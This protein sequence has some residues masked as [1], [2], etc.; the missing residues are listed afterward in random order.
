MP[1]KTE[2]KITKEISPEEIII[3][4]EALLETLKKLIRIPS[5]QGPPAP[6]AP[7]GR[8]TADALDFFLEEADGMGFSVFNVDH[9]AGYLEWGEGEETFGILAHLDVVPAGNN[10]SVCPAY[11]P[12]VKNGRLYGRGCA[13]DKGPAVASLYALKALK[14]AGF[15]PKKKIRLILGLNEESGFGGLTYYLSKHPHV[16]AGF[17][18]DAY[19]PLVHGEKGILSIRYTGSEPLSPGAGQEEGEAAPTAENKGIRLLSIQ[20]GDAL[21]MVASGAETVLRGAP[22]VLAEIEQK[23]D[24]F[25]DENGQK[26][27][28]KRTPGNTDGSD[29]LPHLELKI[30]GKSAH[31][32]TPEKGINAI[33]SLLAF[34]KTIR[35]EQGKTFIDH[36]DRV[37]QKDTTGALLGCRLQ[38]RYG[39]L[40]LNVG[41][42][43][44]RIQNGTISF[45]LDI[46]I[47]YPITARSE[48]VIRQFTE[49]G[50]RQNWST[51]TLELKESLFFDPE[52]PYIQ[53][54]LN[55]YR[56]ISGDRSTPPLTI[57]GGTYARGMKN[58]LGYGMVFPGREV[59]MHQPDEN[60]LLEDL[61]KGA[62]IYA[63]AVQACTS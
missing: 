46:N 39:D 25:C 57:G 17:T 33:S 62:L 19:F 26:G 49:A 3:E 40:T 2:K 60:L 43:R 58:I 22:A 34:L 31:A 41:F 7:Y 10:W 44:S 15:R 20:G 16:D 52:S 45:E 24:R 21:N 23:F 53:T 11:E 12:V 47:R 14:N 35:P 32:S 5:E 4:E 8:A 38:D 27:T 13:D 55:T 54:L 28:L 59:S 1:E 6:N 63:R 29:G 50:S 36:Y 9:H 42:I 18:P 56:D 30:F 61:F 51:R 48:E 37:L